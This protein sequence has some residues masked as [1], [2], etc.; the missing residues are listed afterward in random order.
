MLYTRYIRLCYTPVRALAIFGVLNKPI[1]SFIHKSINSV[2]KIYKT[3]LL[4]NRLQLC[5]TYNVYTHY[6]LMGIY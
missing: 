1:Q 3:H 2:F 5:I 4:I 6:T